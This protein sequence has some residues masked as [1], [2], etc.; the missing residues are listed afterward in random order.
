MS[1]GVGMQSHSDLM[2]LPSRELTE[3]GSPLL[4]LSCVFPCG[5]GIL[6]SEEKENTFIEDLLLV[7]LLLIQG[8]KEPTCTVSFC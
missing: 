2:D 1:F 4:V 6:V 3:I 5:R 7:V 8:R